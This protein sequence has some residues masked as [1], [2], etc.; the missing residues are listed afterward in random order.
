MLR[1][2]GYEDPETRDL[3]VRWTEQQEALSEQDGTSRGHILFEMERS[4]LYVAIGDTDG[5]LE[6]LYHALTQAQQEDE[7]ELERQIV[8]K[9]GELEVSG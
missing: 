5:A 2:R 6:C 7:P 4:E 1:T 9:I 8:Q 3:V